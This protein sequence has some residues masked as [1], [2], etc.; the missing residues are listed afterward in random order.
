MTARTLIGS[1]LAMIL[2]AGC[3]QKAPTSAPAGKPGG[4][5]TIAVIPKGTTHD[6]WTAVHA[7]AKAAAD[8]F[9]V[10]IIWKGPTD[11]GKFSQQISIV[12]DMITQKVDGIVL[13][14]THGQSLKAIILKAYDKGIPLTVFD[15]GADV[16]EDKYVTFAAT[17]NYQG[18]V[19]GARALC[20]LI[21]GKGNVAMV[22][23][24]PGGVSTM[25]REKGFCDTI[26]KEFPD[27]KLVDEKWGYALREK[28]QAAAEDILTA[29][30]DKIDGFFGS[31]ETS[32]V[33]ILLALKQRNLAGKIKFI[34]FDASPDLI[35]GMK[36]GVINGL[37][38]Q[39][40]FKM[41][42]EG[43]KSIVDT[44]AGK[45]VPKRIDTGVVVVTPENMTQPEMAKLLNP[46]KVRPG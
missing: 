44:K 34:G 25:Q 4:K 31:N 29:H 21:G 20:K 11:E 38:V 6:F 27:V 36:E 18:G 28:S 3:Q 22:K 39:N 30:P 33:G 12:E 14:P 35:A 43:V 10:D 15:S 32:A 2:C 40:P 16:P 8:E 9:G 46:P 23:V 17:D 42:F 1:L 24:M 41:G 37:V 19:M 45:Q 26:E 13:A 7:G 5:M